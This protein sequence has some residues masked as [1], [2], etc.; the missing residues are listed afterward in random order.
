MGKFLDS[1]QGQEAPPPAADKPTV[2]G[3]DALDIHAAKRSALKSD[4]VI[5]RLHSQPKFST[6]PRSTL[7]S[8]PTKTAT[9]REAP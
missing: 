1:V 4:E 5:P 9:T 6:G 7:T 8:F 2:L 3:G